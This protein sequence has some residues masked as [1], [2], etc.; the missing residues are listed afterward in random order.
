MKK[1]AILMAVLAVVAFATAPAFAVDISYSGEYRVRQFI[2]TDFDLDDDNGAGAHYFDQRFR[3]TFTVTVSDD[4]MAQMRFD[5]R[6]SM[7]GT[8]DTD[9]PQ[10]DFDAAYLSFNVPGIPMRLI[11]G[12]LPLVVGHAIWW[13]GAVDVVAGVIPSGDWTFGWYWWKVLEDHGTTNHYLY[14]IHP[15]M[16]HAVNA[17]DNP[18]QIDTTTSLGGFAWADGSYYI[19]RKARGIGLPSGTGDD[20]IDEYGAFVTYNGI[21]DNSITFWLMWLQDNAGY[22]MGCLPVNTGDTRTATPTGMPGILDID[23][24]HTANLYNL[25]ADGKIGPVQYQAEGILR[26]EDWD[27]EDT[28]LDI[29]GNEVEDTDG[30]SYVLFATADWYLDDMWYVGL[31]AGVASGN[32]L[33][34]EDNDKWVPPEIGT[35]YF[36]DDN[37]FAPCFILWDDLVGNTQSGYTATAADALDPDDNVFTGV[38]YYAYSDPYFSNGWYIQGRAGVKPTDKLRLDLKI[39][40]AQALEDTLP[41]GADQ[42]DDFGWEIDASIGYKIY[43]NLSFYMGLGYLFAGDFYDGPDNSTF[44][45]D[46]AL[47]LQTK[48]TFTF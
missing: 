36:W 5:A 29:D 32:D 15:N 6:E 1:L 47:E 17:F 7:W 34:D 43:D 21:P 13:N 45:A 19:G 39:T 14:D 48:V 8:L 18:S 3:N 27:Y 46:D 35:D 10:I 22:V 16:S 42:D 24:V 2:Q 37:D 9:Q 11:L 33:D 25:F 30:T 28:I 44:D 12:R 38:T 31:S 4:L 40:Y 20:D 26:L 23:A 41:D